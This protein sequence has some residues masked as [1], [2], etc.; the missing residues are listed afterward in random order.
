MYCSCFRLTILLILFQFLQYF[1]SKAVVSS[2]IC[3][4]HDVTARVLRSHCSVLCW[5][6]IAQLFDASEDWINDDDL[7][8]RSVLQEF[9]LRFPP[10]RLQVRQDRLIHREKKNLPT[11]SRLRSDRLWLMRFDSSERFTPRR[12]GSERKAESDAT[13]SDRYKHFQ[14]SDKAVFL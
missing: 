2:D 11:C 1:E 9:W 14:Q 6:V 5:V 13:F 7:N 3:M 10:R 4:K 8:W 12:E